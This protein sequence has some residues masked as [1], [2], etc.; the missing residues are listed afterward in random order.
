MSQKR[1]TGAR[2]VLIGADGVGKTG[3]TVLKFSFISKSQEYV[4]LY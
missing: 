2:I 1:F 4:L 3:N